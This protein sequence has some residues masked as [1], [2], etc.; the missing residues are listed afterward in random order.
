MDAYDLASKQARL[1]N[2]RS[3]H[4]LLVDSMRYDLGALVRDALT[5]ESTGIATLTSETLLWS[6]LPTTTMR[7]IET[8]ARGLDAL[9]APA[10]EE[11][12]ESLRGRAAEVVRRLRV[13]SREL[14]K[15]DLVPSMLESAPDVVG[16]LPEIASRTAEAV[17]RHISTLAPRTLLFI[18]GD[19]GFTADRRGEI[20]T[21]GASPEEVLVPAFSWLVGELH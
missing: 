20:M 14:Y 12:S 7:Q 15:L 10:R 4:V 19:H 16:S 6:A 3:A 13:G 17:A 5:R 11:P 18:V 9:R 2:A 8:L 21:G 1:S